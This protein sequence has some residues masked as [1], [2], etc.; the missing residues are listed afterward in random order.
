MS[1]I[2]KNFLSNPATLGPTTSPP[3]T[4]TS[5]PPTTPGPTTVP[6]TAGPT[7][8]APTTGAPTT[9]APTTG[10]PT[11][12]AALD[13][14]TYQR[15]AE[16]VVVATGSTANTYGSYTEL[17]SSTVNDSRGLLIH[18]TGQ[19]SDTFRHMF[20]IAVGG[21]G[22]EVDLI[23]DIFT[24]HVADPGLESTV[25]FPMSIPSGSRIS[26]K[27]KWQSAGADDVTLNV[28]S[29]VSDSGGYSNIETFG[30]DG[31][32]TQLD[33]LADPGGVANVKGAWT[34]LIASTGFDYSY[35][36]LQVKADSII[37]TT[38][39]YRLDIATGGAGSEVEIGSSIL[40]YINASNDIILPSRLML[41][42]YIPAGTRLS[43][44]YST[45]I[46]DATDR[47]LRLGG[48][49]IG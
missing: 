35:L 29:I 20:T 9:D 45:D 33:Y 14:I 23:E 7:T 48:W 6:P 16:G 21:A 15:L 3:T 40:F 26:A 39:I 11:T 31:A 37:A 27:A 46:T 49:G 24:M 22:A 25:I 36:G 47:L 13:A 30:I 34:E 4:L 38:G 5:S 18:C 28:M 17:F 44:R 12:A 8:A 2:W 10:A 32:N 43:A 19:T 1:Q 42:A 41:P